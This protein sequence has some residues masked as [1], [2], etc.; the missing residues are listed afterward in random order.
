M[1]VQLAH[2]WGVPSLDGGGVA[3]DSPGIDWQ[4][5]SEGGEGAVLTPLIGGEICGYMGLTG[6]S[7]ILYPQKVILDHE[8]YRSAYEWW[9]GFSFDADDMAL[10]LI[11]AVGPRGHFLAQ[12][13]TR[14]RIRDFRFS[15]LFYQYDANGELLDPHELALEE[16]KR[17]LETHQPRPL[18]GRVERELERILMAAEGEVGG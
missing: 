3:G 1:A 6:G 10:D 5:G 14:R 17:V 4:T 2:A 13:H 9:H 18:P 11:A 15:P 16:F 12:Q 7:M 8:L